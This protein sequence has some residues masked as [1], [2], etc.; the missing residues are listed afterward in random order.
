MDLYTCEPSSTT[1]NSAQTSGSQPEPSSD[2]LGRKSDNASRLGTRA[3]RPEGSCVGQ[4]AGNPRGSSRQFPGATSVSVATY[5]NA[6]L[7]ARLTVIRHGARLWFEAAGVCRALDVCDSVLRRLDPD[8]RVALAIPQAGGVRL[9]TLVSESGL[10]A[11]CGLF[12][13]CGRDVG[14][15]SE[16]A[17]RKWVVYEL[18]P[19][20]QGR[21]VDVESVS[22]SV[23][24]G[25][26]VAA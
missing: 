7:N 15:P 24:S 11:L 21:V 6:A 1:Q 3:L 10:L 22:V 17:F 16:P 19:T 12:T 13:L 2:S 23:A 14:K 26:G 20:V 25:E 9:V 18:L 8:E 5:E 4:V